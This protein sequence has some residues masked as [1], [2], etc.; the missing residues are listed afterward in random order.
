MFSWENPDDRVAIVQMNS[1]LRHARLE[2]L[3]AEC[4]THQ[5]RLRF[6]TEDLARYAEHD[7]LHKAIESAAALNDFYASIERQIPAARQLSRASAPKLSEEQALE[8]SASIS[9]Y[10]R[11]QRDR[12][13]PTGTPLGTECRAIM[14]PFF[15]AALLSRIRI[16]ELAGAA[17]PNPPFY[18]KARELGFSNLPNFSQ[19]ESLTFLD[20]AV[21]NEKVT[22]S[23]L[24]HGLVHAV[25]FQVL[26]LQRYS[27]LLVRGF[28][29]T[30]AHFA[31]PL[32]AH[33]FALESK[34]ARN[35][36][37]SFSVEEQVRLWIREGRY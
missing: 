9:A 11:E 16:V 25:Q 33:A 22:D 6:S 7:L 2:L 31:V 4:A 21:F 13:F 24:F 29:R 12:Y 3:S 1:E 5:L 32:E 36:M 15:T 23:V 17:V 14:Q 19:M 28:L 34:F 30:N 10:V 37:E 18:S 8:F 20:V 27:D 35:G 26:G